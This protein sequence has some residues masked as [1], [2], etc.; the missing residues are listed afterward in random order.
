MG[1]ERALELIAPLRRDRGRGRRRRADRRRSRQV[2]HRSPSRSEYRVEATRRALVGRL[3]HQRTHVEHALQERLLEG[4]VVDAEELHLV[5]ALH[6]EAVGVEEA[7]RRDRQLLK[8]LA[9]FLHPGFADRQPPVGGVAD[10][11]EAKAI[12]LFQRSEP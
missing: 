10:A 6:R 4:D 2:Q 11:D 12:C 8:I 3:D 5:G 7:L 1:P 9:V